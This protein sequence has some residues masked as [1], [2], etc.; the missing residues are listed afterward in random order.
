M[1]PPVTKLA[2]TVMLTIL[3]SACGFQLRGQ[4]AQLTGLGQ[5]L[6]ISGVEPYSEL[7]REL[8][9]QL[10]QAGMRLTSERNEAVSTLL[11][12]QVRSSERVLGLDARNRAA[13]YELMD[14]L[15]FSLRETGRGE[16]LPEQ[17]LRVTRT[18]FTPQDQVLA[19]QQ[20][21]QAL[22]EDMRRELVNLLIR[23]LSVLL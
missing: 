6:F 1:K 19:G 3:L 4:V 10:Q 16:R 7:G 23:R 21:T 2:L 17:T 8:G 22:R 14:S 9:D 12:S 15:R 18:V 5:P 11:I 13:E 20:E